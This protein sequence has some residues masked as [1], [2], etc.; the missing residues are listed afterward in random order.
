MNCAHRTAGLFVQRVE[1]QAG[2]QLGIE[3]G[4]LLRHGLPGVRNLA[5][6]FDAGRIDKK[7]ALAFPGTRRCQGLGKMARIGEVFL[8]GEA[9]RADAQ[10]PLQDD[11]V[12]K[13]DVQVPRGRALLRAE[14]VHQRFVL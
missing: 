3:P 5:D 2:E 13:G 1:R 7:D 10:H 11:L 14:P 8:L 12:Q 9:F 4:G 6:L